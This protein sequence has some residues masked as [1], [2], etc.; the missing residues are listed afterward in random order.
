MSFGTKKYREAILNRETMDPS[1]WENVGE[2]YVGGSEEIADQYGETPSILIEHGCDLG[3]C[4]HCSTHYSH[5]VGFKNRVTGEVIAVGR[6]CGE[7][8]FNFK[9]TA[10]RKVAQ[11][12]KAKA[13]KK[14]R[15]EAAEARQA[16]LDATPGLEDALKTDHYICRDIDARFKRY[17]K[18]SEKQV[19]LVFKIARDVAQREADKANEPAPVAI[20][21]ELAEGRQRFA[22]VVLATKWVDNGFGGCVKM[23]VRDD[24]GFKVWGSA[25]DTADQFKG[26]KVAFDARLTISDDDPCFGFFKRPTK[27]E[28]E[29]AEETSE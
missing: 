5:G 4:E 29:L 27:W 14:A 2:F 22:G 16:V 15:E 24:R 25:P 9:S 23:L 28:V 21:V 3:R 19:N 10:A 13:A 17:G 6:D 18:I 7:Q 1:E 11:A 20:P 8:F 26:A 12:A